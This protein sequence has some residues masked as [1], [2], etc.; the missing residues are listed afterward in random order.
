MSLRSRDTIQSPT[1]MDSKTVATVSIQNRLTTKNLFK[2]KMSNAGLQPCYFGQRRGTQ[3]DENIP[4]TLS[5]HYPLSCPNLYPLSPV[6]LQASAHRHKS[7]NCFPNEIYPNLWNPPL[8]E[9]L[10]LT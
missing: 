9:P 7:A 5:L 8:R 10:S 2:G 3:K 1:F 4:I 6:L